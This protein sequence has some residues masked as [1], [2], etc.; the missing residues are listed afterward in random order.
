MEKSVK[1]GVDI[2]CH[3]TFVLGQDE[4]ET[5]KGVG[6]DLEAGLVD[7]GEEL[8][9]DALSRGLLRDV[10]VVVDVLGLAICARLVV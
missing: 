10:H 1:V 8:P 3:K 6:R 7:P 2:L 4:S 5:V 9:E